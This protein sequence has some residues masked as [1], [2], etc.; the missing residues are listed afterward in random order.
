MIGHAKSTEIILFD[1][2][3]GMKSKDGQLDGLSLLDFKIIKDYD[4]TMRIYTLQVHYQK[5]HLIFLGT[6]QGLSALDCDYK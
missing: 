5:P 6:S 1:I 2:S 3:K 4:K